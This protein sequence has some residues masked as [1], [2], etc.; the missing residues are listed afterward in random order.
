MQVIFSENCLYLFPI[1]FFYYIP[2]SKFFSFNLVRIQ[3]ILIIRFYLLWILI[4]SVV[5]LSK[6]GDKIQYVVKNILKK[7]RRVIHRDKDIT[8]K[9]R[10]FVVVLLQ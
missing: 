4:L 5:I 1:Y 10:Y 2:Q 6:L 7:M 8:K 3:T 9:R